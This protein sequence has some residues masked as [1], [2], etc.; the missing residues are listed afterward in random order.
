MMSLSLSPSHSVSLFL[1]LHLKKWSNGSGRCDSNG[2]YRSQFFS[3]ACGCG[4]IIR[5]PQAKIRL[6]PSFTFYCAAL[7]C[8]IIHRSPVLSATEL[9]LSSCWHWKET[10]SINAKVSMAVWECEMVTM[11]DGVIL[12]VLYSTALLTLWF[13]ELDLRHPV[14]LPFEGNAVPVKLKLTR[15]LWKLV[16]P[17]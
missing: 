15:Q 11:R 1:T 12:A 8:L 10:I 2:S 3:A 16:A 9:L 7:W 13:T 14:S 4:L 5:E 6:I 17:M